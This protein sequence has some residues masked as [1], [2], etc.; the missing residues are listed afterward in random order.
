MTGQNKGRHEAQYR[1]GTA[2]IIAL[3]EHKNVKSYADHVADDL[4]NERNF[5]QSST[6]N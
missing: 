4:K 1:A 3:P 2:L 5:N 6:T